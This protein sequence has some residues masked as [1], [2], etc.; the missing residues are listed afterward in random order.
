MSHYK[1]YVEERRD[2][3]F[4]YERV[5]GFIEW[6]IF[7]KECYIKEIYVCPKFRKQKN[8]IKIFESHV[9]E[10]VKDKCDYITGTVD[11][12]ATC[13]ERNTFLMMEAGYKLLKAEENVITFIKYLKE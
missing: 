5:E 12:T 1:N 7:D 8:T 11:L 4:V 6:Y 10:T 9:I 2:N 3:A 13:P